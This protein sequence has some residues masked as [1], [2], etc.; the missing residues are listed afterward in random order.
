MSSFKREFKVVDD[1]DD[2][3]RRSEDIYRQ[4]R[5]E[6][7]DNILKHTL[8]TPTRQEQDS[9]CDSEKNTKRLNKN[10]K[11][12]QKYI[13]KFLVSISDKRVI[14]M[15]TD[16][17]RYINLLEQ[18]K[19]VTNQKKDLLSKMGPI[20]TWNACVWSEMMNLMKYNILNE[21]NWQMFCANICKTKTALH[22]AAGT[23]S[24]GDK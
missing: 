6:D 17:T 2:D 16:Q 5:R 7:D 15:S 13:G 14:P 18:E 21:D 1:D 23:P 4:T 19:S 10:K 11:K 3:R 20:E 24:K 9:N 22:R 8:S 12:A